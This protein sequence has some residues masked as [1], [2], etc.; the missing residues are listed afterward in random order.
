[1]LEEHIADPEERRFVEPRVTHLL[2]LDEGAAHGKEE[3]FGAW[4]LLFERMSD[5]NPVVLLF[6][7]LQ[8]ADATLVEFISYLLEWSR[9][10]AIYVLCHA[11]PELQERHPE[12]GQ[13]SRNQTTLFLEP[14]SAGAMEALLD[15]FVPGLPDE[16]RQRILSRAEGVPLYAVETVRMLLDRSLLVQEDAIYRLAGAI[17]ELEVPETLQGLIAARLDGLELEERRLLQ[18]AS[19][20]GKT[21][22]KDALAALSG[23]DA[24]ELEP[25]LSALVRKEVLGVQTD[26]RSPERGQYGFLQDLVRRVAYETLARR[27]RKHRHL[28][29]AA[30]LSGK[31]GEVEQEI[32]EVVAAHYLAA[33]EVQ[34]DAADAAEI[35]TRARELLARAGER[36]GSLAAVGEARRYF[37][38]A[39]ELSEEAREKARLLERGGMMAHQNA[40]YDAA[41]RL[42]RAALDLLE[43]VGEPHAAARVSARLAHVEQGTGR[44]EQALERL[45]RA[46]AAVASDEPDDD[47]AALAS[48]LAQTYAIAGQYERAAEPNELALRVAQAQRLP[49]AL[50]RA[51]MTKALLARASDRPEE[52]LALL[53]H[54]LR[55]ALEHDLPESASVAYGNLS[56]A[57]FFGDRYRE[58]LE[59]LEEALAHAR[60]VGDR[61]NE[62]YLLS[63]TSYA[64]AMTGSWNEALAAFAEIPEDQLPAS[65]VHVSVVS[66]VLEIYL[67]RGQL[68]NAQELLSL[69]ADLERTA[70]GEDAAIYAGARAAVHHAAGHHADALK[71]GMQ[72]AGL[73]PIVGAGQQGVKQGLVSAVDAALS[74]GEREP[75][76]ELLASIETL[77]AGLRSPFLEA[78]AQRF[79]ARMNDEEAGFKTAAAGF[80]EYN[81]PFWLAVTELEHGEWLAAHGRASDAEPMVAEAREIFERLEAEP[82]LERA[83]RAGAQAAEVAS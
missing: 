56:D 64:L 10:H 34:P 39:A 31:F 82:W 65:A 27:D 21:F 7:D 55:L 59:V 22:S 58:A 79:R 66:G 57:C 45:E 4:R 17:D 51:L 83:S 67:H 30:F 9:N 14:L 53:R 25:L 80:R 71:A 23:K 38:Q 77:P 24:P 1:M 8:W 81:F 32:V 74:L 28:A 44:A 13:G 62:L 43:A 60:R 46:F 3:L 19:V 18:D 47:I 36:A 78:H 70:K 33:Y 75:A 61:R 26:P 20:L 11:R 15:G 54:A 35:K 76:D 40:E 16:L 72:A 49:E 2:G 73:A 6:E 12:F 50:I 69:F 48:R 63:E 42:F 52:Q 41:E 68:A 5:S 29:T 37:E